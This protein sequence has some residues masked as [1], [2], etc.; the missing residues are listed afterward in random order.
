VVLAVS[1]TRDQ[2]GVI[3][4][5]NGPRCVDAKALRGHS[6]NLVPAA[7]G[8]C[9][10]LFRTRCCVITPAVAV[11]GMHKRSG[12]GPTGLL[13]RGVRGEVLFSSRVLIVVVICR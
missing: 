2:Q 10:Q 3:V 9:R 5:L 12:H 1:V 11:M 4:A 6:G 7:F 13:R 8:H